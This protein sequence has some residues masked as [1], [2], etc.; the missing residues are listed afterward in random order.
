MP[1]D[2][3]D[4]IS[5]LHHGN[6]QIRQVATNHLVTYSSSPSQITLFKHNDLEPLRDL[7]LLIRDYAQISQDALTIMINLTGCGDAEVLECL[8]RDEGFVGEV[9]RKIVD[10]VGA[11]AEKGQGDG[12]ANADLCCALL[13]NLVKDD[14]LAR[15]L[16]KAER[17]VP[18]RTKVRVKL[19]T[20]ERGEVEA[21]KTDEPVSVQIST[22]KRVLD[23]LMD[24]FVKGA[25]NSLNP[26]ANYD[27]LAYVFADLS[28]FEDG[29]RYLLERQEYDGVVPITKLVVFTEHGSLIRRKGI[30]S[31]IKNCAFEVSKHD[32]LLGN[33]SE[34]GVGLLPYLLLPLAG[35]EEFD[36]EDSDGMLVELQ[37]LPPDKEREG[38]DEIVATHLETL[39]LLGT[40]KNG[41][42]VMRKV[43]V[44]PIVRELHL[45]R[46]AEGIQEGCVR[47]VN[48]LMRDEGGEEEQ[49]H[50]SIKAKEDDDYKIEEVF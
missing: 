1:T 48:V 9:V 17:G 13:A 32:Y 15:R 44:Y 20:N 40:E 30:A 6:T 25:N 50:N 24:V 45:K 27:Y 42:D 49:K 23:Q 11:P 38:D 31:T 18:P 21:T 41:R 14:E 29:R 47:L 34:G 39:L 16:L 37:L 35:N 8:S 12:S 36:A 7:K 4:L 22:S 2:L 5:F 26:N 19:K 43:K 46:E 3:E 10:D 33:E 28:K